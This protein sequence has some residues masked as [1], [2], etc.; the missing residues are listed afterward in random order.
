LRQLRKEWSLAHGGED[1][2]VRSGEAVQ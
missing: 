1:P 2:A